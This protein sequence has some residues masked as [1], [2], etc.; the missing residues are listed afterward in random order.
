MDHPRVYV[1]GVDV[2]G[3]DYGYSDFFLDITDYVRG[4]KEA[5]LEIRTFAHAQPASRWYT[6]AG[7]YRPVHLY[8]SDGE[9]IRPD[10]LRVWTKELTKEL[11][12]EQ[13]TLALSAQMASGGEGQIVYEVYDGNEKLAQTKAKA[14]ETA[15][16]VLS[17][18]TPWSASCPRLYRLVATAGKD[19]E[20]LSFGIRTIRW[21]DEGL[22]INGQREIL[23]GACI[24]HDNGLLGA[25][26]HP[27]A[28][29]RKI[30]LLKACGYNAIRSAHNPCSKSLLSACDAFGMYVLDEYTD[31]WYIHKT[32][33]DYASYMEKNWRTDLADM[34]DKDFSHPS[35]IMYSTGNEVAETGQKKGIHL[36]KEMTEYLHRI[37]GTR[38]VTCGV[39]I[40]FNL[41]YAMGFGVYSDEKSA[42]EEKRAGKAPQE[43]H[44]AAGKKAVGSEFYN[45][46]AGLLGDKTMKMGAT[47]YPCDLLT[48]DAFAA[49]DVAGYNYGINRYRHD[50]K[51]YPHRLILGTET[52]CRDAFAFY[53][54]AKKEKRLV[55]DFV[56]AGMDYIGEAGIGAWEYGEY[57]PANADPSGWLTAGSGRLDITGYA[58][59]EALYTKVALEQTEEI[60]IAVRPVCVSGKHSPS[61]WKMTEAIPSWSYGGFEGRKAHVEVYARAHKVILYCNRRKIGE[62][63]RRQ[64]KDGCRFCFTL[65]YEPG[66]LQAVALDEAG[67]M[68]GKRTLRSAGEQTILHIQPERE[69][70]RG[71]QEMPAFAGADGSKEGQIV[72]IPI[73]YGDEKGI[74]K[75]AVNGRLSIQTNDCRLLGFGNGC[76]YNPD[77]YRGNRTNTYYGRAMAIVQIC[78]PSPSVAVTDGRRKATARL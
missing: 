37:D 62:R 55:G 68:L 43:D 22:M 26:S 65:P 56:W 40:F 31:M 9:A 2:G 32:K 18:I 7:L 4:K 46:L 14:G 52:F 45:R 13:A 10:S 69:T 41:L 29:Y 76:S 39:N 11:T 78:G 35:V 28:E 61:A 49:M 34:V 73:W 58:T 77:G 27:A 57:V 19:K 74:E 47:L 6:G 64:A 5:V 51:K 16:L 36:T 42:R 12:K 54:L 8:T 15:S 1:D 72:Y 48:R 17:G 38:S 53:E 3:R 71:G 33:H 23:R 75:P 67:R 25:I 60:Y 50:L 30:R 24:H 63:I 44:T 20:E 66:L 21:G 59:G 70:A